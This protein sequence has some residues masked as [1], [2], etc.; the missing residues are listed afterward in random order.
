[1][2]NKGK[3]FD[4]SEEEEIMAL[5]LSLSLSLSNSPKLLFLGHL[6]HPNASTS[7]CV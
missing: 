5:V 2:R 1:M 7:K 3:I 6:H 4:K